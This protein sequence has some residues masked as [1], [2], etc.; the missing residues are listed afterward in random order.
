LYSGDL[1][2]DIETMARVVV[3]RP[4]L[5][6]P[7][8][9]I[10]ELLRKRGRLVVDDVELAWQPGQASALEHWEVAKGRDVGTVTAS[11]K[12]TEGRRHDVPYDVTF[13]FVI[14]A[15]HPDLSILK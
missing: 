8:A 14:H 1:P 12:D 9:V 6:K 2:K 10:L 15:F 7:K 5:G 4:S 13:A 11:V 3:V